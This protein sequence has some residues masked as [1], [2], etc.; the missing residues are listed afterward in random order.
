MRQREDKNLLHPVAVTRSCP[1]HPPCPGLARCHLQV[2]CIQ[3]VMAGAICVTLPAGLSS[4]GQTHLAPPGSG[5]AGTLSAV[6]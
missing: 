3:L 6:L 4:P 5:V 2:L 1:L